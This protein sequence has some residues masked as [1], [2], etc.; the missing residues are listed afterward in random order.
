M[1]GRHGSTRS[2]KRDAGAVEVGIPSLLAGVLSACEQRVLTGMAITAQLTCGGREA[3]WRTSSP[4][5]KNFYG[6]ND[7]LDIWTRT[8]VCKN[9]TTNEVSTTQ[10]KTMSQ[11]VSPEKKHSVADL[12]SENIAV[13]ENSSTV[14]PFLCI[15]SCGRS[16]SSHLFMKPGTSASNPTQHAVGI[17]MSFCSAELQTSSP[18][19]P[20]P[21][22]VNCVCFPA[23]SPPYC[24]MWELCQMMQ[25]VGG[26]SWDL[27][28]PPP[29]HSDAAPYSPRFTINSQVLYAQDQHP[30]VHW[31]KIHPTHT[32]VVAQGYS[33]HVSVVP[34]QY[35][36]IFHTH[37]HT[38]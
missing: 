30:V 34:P 13:D 33:P 32:I 26:F 27:P 10:N 17:P 28:F 9:P 37:T 14:P 1:H 19:P 2:L 35:L 38:Q 23:G 5:L 11:V 24:H 20:L 36:P 8:M 29:L 18:F 6:F 16:V 7:Y 31:P 22:K 12:V 25:L 3:H 4:T 15:W 21:S